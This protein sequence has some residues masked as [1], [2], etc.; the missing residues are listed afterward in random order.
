LQLFDGDFV[1]VLHYLSIDDIPVD[2]DTTQSAE[3][4][5]AD[6]STRRTQS[7]SLVVHSRQGRDGSSLPVGHRV[8]ASPCD[9]HA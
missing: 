7:G 3:I 9:R 6:E 2:I 1:E 4:E 5:P 8:G